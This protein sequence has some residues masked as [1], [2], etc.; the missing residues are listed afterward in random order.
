LTATPSSIA[1]RIGKS[2]SRKTSRAKSVTSALPDSIM[3][4]ACSGSVMIPTAPTGKSGT[5]F[6]MCSAN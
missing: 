5:F 4:L 6:L 2:I 3:S 1:A